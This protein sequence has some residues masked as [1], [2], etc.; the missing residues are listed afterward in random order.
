VNAGARLIAARVT[1]VTPDGDEWILAMRD[2]TIR[3]D[4][5]LGADGPNSLVRRRVL[6]P[7]ARADLSI[8]TGFFV[9]GRTSREIAIA[10]EDDPPGYLWSFPRQDHL[11]VGVCAQADDSSVSALL[12][13]ASRWIARNVT[14]AVQLERYSWPIPSLRVATLECESP[15]GPR[16]MLLGDAGGMVDPITREGI[17]FAVLSGNA[18]ADC[19]LGGGDPTARYAQRIRDSVHA[20]LIRAARLKARFFNPRF[21][22]LL[23]HSL[24]RSAAIRG[25]MADLISGRQTYHGLRR[26]LIG[27]FE[28][29]LMLALLRSRA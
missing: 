16:W 21:T 8:A 11:A 14:G 10:F 1:N 9:H 20:E 7:F 29:G 6:R 26:R 27:T 18:A 24:Q 13:M 25:V 17:F 3:S 15:A 4:W 12:P 5:L 28:L 23:V 22:R 19:L 2:G